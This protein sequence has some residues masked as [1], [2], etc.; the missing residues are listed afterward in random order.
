MLA[1]HQVDTESQSEPRETETHL[2]GI[3]GR[4]QVMLPDPQA[5]DESEKAESF[6]MLTA[7]IWSFLAGEAQK[8]TPVA[9]LGE[10]RTVQP[11]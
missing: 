5:E 2:F 4:F 8:A 1:N 11:A 9:P 3:G 10:S 6:L 7:S